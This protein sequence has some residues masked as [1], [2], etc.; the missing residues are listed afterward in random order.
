MKET[1]TTKYYKCI[2]I[3][4]RIRQTCEEGILGKYRCN[5]PRN[6]INEKLIIG[7]LNVYIVEIILTVNECMSVLLECYEGR[8]RGSFRLCYLIWFS[9]EKHEFQEEGGALITCKSGL[10][11]TK[12]ICFL[13]RMVDRVL[14]KNYIV[15]PRESLTRPHRLMVLDIF[16][17]NNKTKNTFDR[18]L[19]TRWWK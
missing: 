1:R 3:R 18:N 14:C 17:R 15:I 4:S 10:N 19:K 2:F 6:T 9:Y 5:Y 13:T 16:I 8:R 7:D 11:F 12:Y